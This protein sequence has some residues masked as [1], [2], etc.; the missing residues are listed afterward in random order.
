MGTIKVSSA[1][2]MV[3][4]GRANQHDASYVIGIQGVG[5][6]VGRRVVSFAAFTNWHA[7]G[8]SPCGAAAPSDPSRSR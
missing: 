7:K 8:K 3:E 4:P 1:V 2:V 6:R 5:G